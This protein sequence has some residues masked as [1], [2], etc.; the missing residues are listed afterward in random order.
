[1]NTIQSFLILLIVYPA[2]IYGFTFVVQSKSFN[3]PIVSTDALMMAIMR[4]LFAFPNIAITLIVA[5]IKVDDY[6]PLV[7]SLAALSGLAFYLGRMTN[8]NYTRAISLSCVGEVVALFSVALY[9]T[10]R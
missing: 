6:T 2:S 7:T 5:N 1:M 9:V 10:H 3:K 8:V 4:M